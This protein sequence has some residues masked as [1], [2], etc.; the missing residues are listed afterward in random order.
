MHKHEIKE[1]KKENT[2]KNINHINLNS[3]KKRTNSLEKARK[4]L[5]FL[6]HLKIT[7]KHNTTK[8]QNISLHF[9]KS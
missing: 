5:E 4:K 2:T 9:F 7:K 3:H 1:S 6:S 8:K